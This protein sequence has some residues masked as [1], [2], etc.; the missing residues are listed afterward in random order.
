MNRS[1][2]DEF[3]N[4]LRPHLLPIQTRLEGELRSSVERAGLKVQSIRGRIKE[5]SSL[6]RKLSRPD[7]SYLSLYDVTDLLA[8]RIITY[9][10]DLIAD[11]ARVIEQNFDVDFRNSV[12]KLQYEDSDKFGYRSLHYVC[13]FP[14]ELR[15][16]FGEKFRFEIQIRTVL[17][18]TWAEIE[19]D[20]GYKATEQLPREFRRRFSQIA[21]LL[22]V[23][24]REFAAIRT[25]LKAYVN[26]LKAT[27]LDFEDV[28]LDH[29][30]LQSALARD[31][32]LQ[33]DRA[34]SSYLSVPI[35]EDAFYPDYVLSAARAAGIRRVSDLLRN[36]SNFREAMQKFLPLYFEFAKKQWGLERASIFAVQRGYAILFLA[37]LYILES[38]EL[39]INKV[40]RLTEYYRETD[41]PGDLASAKSAAHAL[42]EVLKAN[43]LIQE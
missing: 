33:L 36:A 31:E 11:V 9:S 19:H 40:N 38:E 29:L 16:T 3:E 2:L 1:F 13:A 43:R 35:V 21:S 41:Y 17:Q 6:E 23:A 39:F 24:D 5:R 20:I 12:N 27:N 25:D 32:M 18:H 26:K 37:H 22:E 7:R 15:A 10:E 8:F 42:V 34:V 4:D 30:S 14:Y 28:E